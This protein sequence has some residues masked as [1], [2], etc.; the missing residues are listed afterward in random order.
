MSER[1]YFKDSYRLEFESEVTEVT[2]IDQRPAVRLV[3]T[4]FYPTGGG[5]PHDTGALNGVEVVDVQSFTKDGPVWH[6]LA[7]EIPL[8]TRVEANIDPMRRWDH[9]QHHT[10]QHLLTRAFIEVLGAKTLSFHLS[11]QRVT[12]DIEKA[13]LS[14]EAVKDVE[15]LVN[16][17]I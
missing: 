6:L 10:G 17:V 9:M 1:L 5:Q 11:P 2:T 12:I 3:G 7:K 4:Y 16:E 13:N 14:R 15:R 8:G